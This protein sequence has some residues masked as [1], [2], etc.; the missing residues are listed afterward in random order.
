MAMQKKRR[1]PRAPFIVTVTAAA[2]LGAIAAL[3]GCGTSVTDATDPDGCYPEG[4]VACNPPLPQCPDSVPAQGAACD[5]APQ[6]CEYPGDGACVERVIA[7]CGSDFTWSVEEV[8]SCIQCPAEMPA[9][10][11]P[12]SLPPDQTCTYTVDTGCGPMD[13]FMSCAEG[14]WQGGPP[15]CN[16]PPPETCYTLATEGEC[17]SLAPFCRWL[18]PGCADATVPPPPLSQAGCFPEWDCAAG[19]ICPAGTSCMQVVIDPCYDL[20]CD[21]CAA[22]ASLCTAP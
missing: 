18:V 11:T 4:P 20:P 10:G 21:A 2:S 13:A 19:D 5:T 9:G 15:T 22:T 17:T 6:G 7:T 8:S 3:P 12:C 14:V 16:P 1:V